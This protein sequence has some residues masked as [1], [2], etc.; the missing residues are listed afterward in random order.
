MELDITQPTPA[1]PDARLLP[2]DLNIAPDAFIASSAVL[3]GAVSVGARASVWFGSILRGDLAPVIVGADSNVQDL[4]ILHVEVDGPVVL[5]E[6]VTVG[7]RAVVHG[8]VVENDCLIGI[9]AVILSG[10]RIGDHSIIGAG[11]LVPEG[12]QIPPRSVVLGVPGKVVRQVTDE[13]LQ[14]VDRNWRVYVQYAG[15]YRLTEPAQAAP[16]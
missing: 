4:S 8:C 7:H 11:A 6:R 10:A 5:G 16:R 14:R 3:R 15:H 12:K 1:G 13:E 2:T 9:G